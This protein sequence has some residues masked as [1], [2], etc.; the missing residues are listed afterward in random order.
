M[1]GGSDWTAGVAQCRACP[2]PSTAELES[3]RVDLDRLA[4]CGYPEVVYAEGKTVGRWSRFCALSGARAGLP[5]D[6]VSAEQGEALV[7][8]FPEVMEPRGRLRAMERVPGRRPRT[9]VGGDGRNHDRPV[10]E[11]AVETLGWMRAVSTVLRTWGCRPHRLLER[12]EPASAMPSW[13]LRGWRG[14]A[15]RGGRVGAARWGPVPTSVGYG[16]PWGPGRV[17]GCSTAAPPMSRWST[18]S[19]LQ[20]RVRRRPDR[21]GGRGP[22]AEGE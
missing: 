15:E 8:R 7:E 14:V 20:G 3:A 18:S 1:V 2:A 6:R 21:T 10:A 17:W 16:A 22:C 5:G 9:C 11:E 4:R 13:W 12:R 19:R